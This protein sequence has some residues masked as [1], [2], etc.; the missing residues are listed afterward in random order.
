[1][2]E[3]TPVTS[4]VA[5]DAAARQVATVSHDSAIGRITLAAT[6]TALLYCA[7]ETPEQAAARIGRTFPTVPGPSSRHMTVLDAARSQ[8]DDYLAGRRRD[9]ALPLDLSLASE[10][11]REAV[12]GLGAVAPYGSTSTYGE[13]AAA[14]GRPRAARA[15]G[16]A[17]GANPLCVVLPCHRAVGVSGRLT[18]YAGGLEAKAFL[19]DLERTGTTR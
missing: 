2:P 3:T 9:F 8:L 4:A 7:F 15:V 6:G 14:I 17:L 19:L 10:F 18:G 12:T 13:L 5:G 11:T 16:R 1:M